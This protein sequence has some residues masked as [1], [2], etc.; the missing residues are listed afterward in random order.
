MKKGEFIALSACTMMLT[1]LG[2]DIM[3][4]VFGELKKYFHLSVNSTATAQ[5]VTFFFLGQTAQIIFGVLSDRFGRLAILR[6]GFPLYIIGGTAATFAPSLALMF[7]ARFVAGI[8]A[9]AVFMTTIAGVRDRFAGDQ[10][11]RTLSLIFTIFLSTP[12][13]APFLGLAIMS[14]AS[15]HM[16]F[17]TPPL[18][19]VIVFVWSLRLEESHPKEKRNALNW[20]SFTKSIRKVLSNKT[21]LRYTCITTALFAGLSSW[22]SSSEHIVSEIYR[23]PNLFA[24]IF[25]ATGLWMALSTLTNA[26]LSI[27]FGARQTI[28]WL[29]IIYTSIATILLIWSIIFGDPPQMIMFFISVAMLMGINLAVE[30]NSSALAMQPMGETAG[31]ASAVYGTFFFFVGASFGSITSSLMKSSVFPI[32]ISFFIAGIITLILVFTDKRPITSQ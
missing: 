5:I 6:L 14:I 31:I 7:T 10:M 29:L 19:A 32:I 20:N 24:W 27:K 11:A 22:V 15:W 16:V 26:R 3:L 17:L 2:I 4:P 30:P 18:F 21:F 13:F 28:K 8:G 23:K 12:V 1:A 9:S 25:A